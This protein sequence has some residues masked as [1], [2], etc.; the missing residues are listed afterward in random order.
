[1]PRRN[2]TIAEGLRPL[3]TSMQ[4]VGL[5]FSRPP[6][7]AGDDRK[8][9]SRK[10]TA[11]KT[12]AVAVVVLLWINAVR[13]FS[14]FT[15][16]DEFGL[17]LFDKLIAVA[18]FVQCAVS[19]TAFFAAG[20]GGRLAVVLDQVLDDA[21]ARR[22]RR[23]SVVCAV[24]AWSVIVASLVFFAYGALSADGNDLYLAPL[25]NHIVVSNP[26]IPR[27]AACFVIFYVLTAYTFSQTATFVLAMVFSHQFRTVDE[28]LRRLLETLGRLLENGRCRVSESDVE[29]L[30]RQHQRISTNVR[31]ADDCLMF[32]TAS[33]FCSQ[34]FCVIMMLFSI[35]FYHPLIND[36]VII[37]AYV[38]T[39]S[40]VS[41]GLALTVAG[42]ITVHHYVSVF[43]YLS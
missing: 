37:V 32:S 31:R 26:L 7:D 11:Y 39:V 14:V 40:T 23:Y 29:T 41:F 38:F 5:Y 3:L 25:Q 18:W 13:M 2:V 43:D 16:E 33:S 19:Q 35:I 17:L 34:L 28:T 4:T 30:R 8:E 1:M 20:H 12:Y 10:W 6:E 9:N 36:L 24:V 22:A 21:S 15:G 42:G 27:I